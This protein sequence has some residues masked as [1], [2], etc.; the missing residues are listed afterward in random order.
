LF[1]TEPQAKSILS[2]YGFTIPKGQLI[3]DPEAAEQVA[4]T[5]S[6]VAMKVLIP[7]W[8]RG[9]KGGVKHTADP[10]EAR[11]IVRQYLASDFDGHSVQGVLMEE[12]ISLEKEYYLSI[13]N[14]RAA[15]G[16]V[17]I[18]SSTGGVDVEEL[19]QEYAQSVV[20]EGFSIREGLPT[21]K[22]RDM[23][24]RAGVDRSHL[25]KMGQLMSRLAKVYQDYDA[26]LVEINPLGVA[27]DGRLIALDCKMLVDDN[28]LY[29]H[30][31]LTGMSDDGLNE[32][33]LFAKERGFGYVEFNYLGEIACAATG[34][35]LGL[36]AMDLINDTCPGSLAFFLDVGGRFVGS[37][38]DVIKLAQ[39]F[40]NIKAILVNR[41]GGFGRGQVIAESM[42][43]GLLEAKPEVPVMLSLSG[44]GEKAAIEYFKEMEHKV[45]EAGITFEWTSHVATG[46]ETGCSRRGDVDVIEYP[47][48]RVV[49]WAGYEY[50]RRPPDW[51]PQRYEW[52]NVTRNLVTEAMKKRPEK[53]YRELSKGDRVAECQS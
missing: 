27:S 25:G 44:S 3:Q 49:E 6:E 24:R 38:G 16:P 10:Q 43:D 1:L 26:E 12:F 48:K 23:A 31:N 50:K 40:P 20:Q 13:T 52:E 53:E 42:I 35:G 9:K 2:E 7:A 36:T 41:Y 14:S 34:A 32:R 39:M 19:V 51:L 37:T 29:R 8:G 45:L 4:E 22:A 47:V 11:E 5:L 17:A 28:S 15:K 33:Q 21:Y 46:T 30:K 18:V